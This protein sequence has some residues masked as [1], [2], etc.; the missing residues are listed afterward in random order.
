MR[1]FF[2]AIVCVCLFSFSGIGQEKYTISGYLKDA[3]SKEALIGAT[4]YVSELATGTASNTYGFYSLT[5]QEGV[6]QLSFDYLGYTSQRKEVALNQDLDLNVFL[7][8]YTTEIAEVVVT[9]TKIKAIENV[10]RPQVG[11]IDLQAKEIKELPALGGEKD[12][13]KALVLLPGVQSGSEGSAGFYVRGGG[14]D[15]NLILLDEAVVYN[16]YHL[17]GFLSVFNVDAI[18]N[19]NLIKGGYPAKF[20]GRLS[21]I[22]DISMKEGNMNSYHGEG[23]IGTEGRSEIACSQRRENRAA[24]IVLLRSQCQ[25]KLQ[26][27][28]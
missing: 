2:S 11:I 9:D 15:Q 7:E 8:E 6:Y 20:G 21:S 12:I 25:D 18:K 24:R 1:Y 14:P 26:V 17:F 5:L 22:L 10:E 27:L 28:R 3:S 23:G 19:V 13:L 4:V 16:P